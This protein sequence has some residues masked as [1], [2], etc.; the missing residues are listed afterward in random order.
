MNHVLPIILSTGTLVFSFVIVALTWMWRR[1][2]SAQLAQ[3]KQIA[4]KL[5]ARAE[6]QDMIL[7]GSDSLMLIWGMEQEAPH[8]LGQLALV[9][10]PMVNRS[11]IT[12][13]DRWLTPVSAA[14]LTKSLS[15]LKFSGA[16]FKEHLTTLDGQVLLA[17]GIILAEFA[18]VTFYN[19]NIDADTLNDLGHLRSSLKSKEESLD[20]LLATIPQPVW[21]LSVYGDINRCN[22]AFR[23]LL[24]QPDMTQPVANF[25]STKTQQKV[26]QQA[27]TLRANQ[28]RRALMDVDDEGVQ[29]QI[30]LIR[31]NG[32]VLVRATEQVTP[33][34][35]NKQ[36]KKPADEMSR[37]VNHLKLPIALFDADNVMVQAN[38]AFIELFGLSLAWVSRCP[39]LGEMLDKL[40]YLDQLP[41]KTDYRDWRAALLALK[42]QNQSF[43]ELWHLP[44]GRTLECR[45]QK[46]KQ[47]GLTFS[48][49]D[50][51]EALNLKSKNNELE[52]VQS[53]TI[54]ALNEAV[55]V[56]GTDGRLR[57]FNPGLSRI[58]GL[59]TSML[60]KNPHVSEL[61]MHIGADAENDEVKAS[62]LKA[63]QR[64]KDYPLTLG[65]IRGA[66]RGDLKFKRTDKHHMSV[67]YA[68][69]PLP[70]GQTMMTFADISDS[71]RLTRAL[72]ERNAALEKADALKDAFVRHVSYEFRQPLNAI[73]GFTDFLAEP[74]TGPLNEKQRE[75]VT[76]VQRSSK[77]LG[78]LVNNVLD[79]ASLDAGI[80]ELD[81]KSEDIGDLV[82]EAWGAVKNQLEPSLVGAIRLEAT[83]PPNL[84]PIK[85]DRLRMVQILY[86]VMANAVRSSGEDA[87]IRL[88]CVQTQDYTLLQ[89]D[90]DGAGIEQDRLPF[91]FDR[92]VAQS[93]KVYPGGAGLGLS[94]VKSLMQLHG[95]QVDVR[96]VPG[97]GTQVIL[98]L[99]RHYEGAKTNKVA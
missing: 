47:G 92:F 51:S 81:K 52:R 61:T 69:V 50:I 86:N 19:S 33:E 46:D 9:D 6:L 22:D 15:E 2:Q 66:K 21:V 26:A 89:I 1:K 30:E 3:A 32:D 13:F 53:E 4:A 67:A 35:E 37:A 48:F 40:R 78:M 27:D 72:E 42:D 28:R 44:D 85:V 55:A 25:L 64:L 58:W 62:I 34:L 71:E 79:L 12:D 20:V 5:K 88:S 7:E 56:F 41:P 65:G 97:E 31:L 29:Y 57:L 68:V 90:D 98:R 99:P 10:N 82:Q 96:S 60:E 8:V 36:V 94:V 76:Y 38:E 54:N 24:D 11:D 49:E 93:T 43:D 74:D 87:E 83:V 63:W 84:S 45:A 73:I 39:G 59:Q 95:G 14:I 75:Y 16:G 91:I 80:I 77:A 23:A 17:K 18:V 70:D